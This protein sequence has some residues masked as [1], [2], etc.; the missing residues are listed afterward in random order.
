LGQHQFTYAVYSHDRD[1]QAGQTVRRAAELNQPLRVLNLSPT[2]LRP[3]GQANLPPVGEFLS[4]PANFMLTAFKPSE[5][6]SPTSPSQWILRGY[7]CHGSSGQ[8]NWQNGLGATLKQVLNPSATRLNLLEQ[9]VSEPVGPIS[10]W[11]I[12]TYRFNRV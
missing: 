7:E 4:L 5:E 3:V 10:P 12:T 2:S 1:W 8:L 9:P 11:Q 6:S